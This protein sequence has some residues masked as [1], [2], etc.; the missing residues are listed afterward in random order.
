MPAGIWRL[1]QAEK[2]TASQNKRS[3]TTPSSENIAPALRRPPASAHA[4]L[5]HAALQRGSTKLLGR[6]QTALRPPQRL[7][8]TRKPSCM[9]LY[10]T[11]PVQTGDR[12]NSLL[13]LKSPFSTRQRHKNCRNRSQHVKVSSFWGQ[14][15]GSGSWRE[16]KNFVKCRI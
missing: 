4:H 9:V 2:P 5:C 8:L 12:R 6:P 15:I 11:L 1:R 7:F 10:Y 13:D 14:L 16:S 3:L